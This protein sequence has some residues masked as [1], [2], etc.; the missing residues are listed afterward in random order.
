[1]KKCKNCRDCAVYDKEYDS[2]R[3]DLDDV[4][5]VDEP[6]R[7][8]HFCMVYDREDHTCIPEDVWSGKRPCPKIYEDEE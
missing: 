6:V 2:M 5:V 3:Q 4:I 1:M 8:K 7:E